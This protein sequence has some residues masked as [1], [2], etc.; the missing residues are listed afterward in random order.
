M[1]DEPARANLHVH[2]SADLYDRY[3]ER[4]L[5]W[6]D[7]F[8]IR[9]LLFE[10]RGRPMGGVLLD[11]GTGTA[12]LLLKMALRPEF[13]ALRFIGTDYFPDMVELAARNARASGLAGRVEIL[14]ADVHA[15]PFPDQSAFLVI[16]RSTLHHWA[17]PV[18]A[19]REIY[20]VLQPGGL[21]LI[22]DV[23]RD[24]TPQ[25]LR[26]FNQ[27]RQVASV[28]PSRLEE[29]YT[30]EEIR[31]FAAEAGLASRCRISAPMR[32]PASLGIELRI[33]R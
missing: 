14:H 30:T 4:F 32:G 16:S 2:Y 33:V 18:A 1:K 6:Y 20:R 11:A 17:Q 27:M 15:L 21:A 10:C 13:K 26:E 5:D 28:E 12:R 23:R 29:K 8:M 24:S 7:D 22:H 3:R 19:L 25:A 31:S 9:R